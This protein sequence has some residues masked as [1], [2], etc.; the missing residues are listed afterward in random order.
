MDETCSIVSSLLKPE[1]SRGPFDY[2]N[3]SKV[4]LSKCD[5][6][7]NSVNAVIVN[8]T[9][10]KKTPLMVYDI[11]LAHLDEIFF[12]RPVYRNVGDYLGSAADRLRIFQKKFKDLEKSINGEVSSIDLERS[13][14]IFADSN[15]FLFKIQRVYVELYDIKISDEVSL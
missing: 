15:D 7:F 5:E 2:I 9:Y 10:N 14:K 3:L 11:M 12:D 8:R 4:T 13:K 1:E 6:I